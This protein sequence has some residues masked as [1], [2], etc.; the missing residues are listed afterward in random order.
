[1]DKTEYT[2]EYI[3]YDNFFSS[4]IIFLKHEQQE[5]VRL[6]VPFAT[7]KSVEKHANFQIDGVDGLLTFKMSA[8]VGIMNIKVEVGGVEV[9]HN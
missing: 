8:V 1:L 5:L 2:L 6:V 7:L 4:Q 3:R 9:F